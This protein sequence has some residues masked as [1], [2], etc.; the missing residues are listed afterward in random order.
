MVIG[1]D[2]GVAAALDSR[3]RV[4]TIAGEDVIGKGVPK[5][6]DGAAMIGQG[7]TKGDDPSI[8]SISGVANEASDPP[9]GDIDDRIGQDFFAD[10]KRDRI[11]D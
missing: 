10:R 9:T 3:A 4:E 8:S 6:V 5:G 11:G 7:A 2:C 1:R